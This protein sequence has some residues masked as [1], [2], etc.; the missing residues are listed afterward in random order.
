MKTFLTSTA[1]ALAL[2]SPAMAENTATNATQGQMDPDAMFAAHAQTGSVT[3]SDLIGAR[4]YTSEK[5]ISDDAMGMSDEWNDV[6]EVHDI[7]LGKDGEVDYVIADIGGFLGIGEKSVAVNMRDLRFVSDGEE[8]DEWFL[9]LTAAKADL[10]NAPNYGGAM[11]EDHASTTAMTEENQPRPMDQ[12]G[13]MTA[14]VATISAD[15]MAGQRVYDSNGEWIGEVHELVGTGAEMQAVIDVGGFL[16]IGEKPVAV[17]LSDLTIQ[18]RDDGDDLRIYVNA[19][20][21]QLE[22]MPEYEG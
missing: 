3:A 10:E 8:A 12:D 18:S 11:Q 1:I 4:L 22:A 14:D 7:V 5:D 13:Y 16:G 2:A 21:E 20:E 19:T 9:V 17:S 6:G 15:R